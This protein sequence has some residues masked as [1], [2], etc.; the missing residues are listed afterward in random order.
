MCI[1]ACA[2]H[3][4]LSVGSSALMS[5]GLANGVCCS[6]HAVSAL[7]FFSLDWGWGFQPTDY[8]R[9]WRQVSG[10]P[11]SGC[12]VRCRPFQ[13]QGDECQR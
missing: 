2:K 11:R 8:G 10:L 1:T 7:V 12:G 3:A 5:A 9:G 4:P 6:L 13:P